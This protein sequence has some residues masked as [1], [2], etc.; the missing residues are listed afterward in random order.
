MSVPFLGASSDVLQGVTLIIVVITL[1]VLG[2]AVAR[3]SHAVHLL[4]CARMTDQLTQQVIT[5]EREDYFQHPPD[6][7]SERRT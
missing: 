1:G 7:P 6:T 2:K 5:L 3:L 4:A